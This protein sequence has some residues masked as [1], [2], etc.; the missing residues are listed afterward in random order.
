MCDRTTRC[1]DSSSSSA[2]L[3]DCFS[4]EG[5]VIGECPFFPGEECGEVEGLPTM[6]VG[7]E[8]EEGRRKGD[9]RGE[10]KDNGDGLYVDACATVSTTSA[11]VDF[12]GVSTM[13]E[14]PML[15]LCYSKQI[16]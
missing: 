6:V 10:L 5:D 1:S 8:G 2:T 3:K 14:K 13:I 16:T 12:A 9:A 11:G 15:L 4:L 7:D